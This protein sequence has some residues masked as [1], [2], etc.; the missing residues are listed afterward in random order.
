MCQPAFR[1]TQQPPAL[2][3]INLNAGIHVIRAEVAASEQHQQQGLMFRKTL[4]QNDG[5]LFVYRAPA[6]VCMWMKNT[7]IPLSVTFAF[8]DGDGRIVNVEEM[9][10]QTL[11]SHCGK[12]PVRYALEMNRGWF[13][14]K[15]LKPGDLIDGLPRLTRLTVY[16]AHAS[17]FSAPSSLRQKNIPCAVFFKRQEIHGHVLVFSGIPTKN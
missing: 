6:Q 14:Q 15:N 4:G 1:P 16:H 5:M 10:P 8:I 3:V 2:P 13:R 12:K 17:K 11:D 7:L 9:Q